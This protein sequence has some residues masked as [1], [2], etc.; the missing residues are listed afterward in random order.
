MSMGV[1]D[2]P[3]EWLLYSGFSVT[4]GFVHLYTLFMVSHLHSMA[5][6]DRSR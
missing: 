1:I 2:Q 3:I 4:L 5:K 6:I